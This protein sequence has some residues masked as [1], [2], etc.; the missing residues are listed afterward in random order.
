MARS[1]GS[2]NTSIRKILERDNYVSQDELPHSN[3]EELAWY[4]T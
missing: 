1:L 3:L 4:V 2:S